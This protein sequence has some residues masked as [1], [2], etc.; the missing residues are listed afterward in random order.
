MNPLHEFKVRDLIKPS[1]NHP[2]I[3]MHVGLAGCMLDSVSK[4]ISRAIPINWKEHSKMK[5][6]KGLHL[7]STA[8]LLAA[9]T[10]LVSQDP[11]ESG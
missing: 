7:L 10:G 5:L 4:P 8:V 1:P 11:P 6:R 3:L 9:P 2:E